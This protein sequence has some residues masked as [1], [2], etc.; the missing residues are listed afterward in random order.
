MNLVGHLGLLAN[1]LLPIDAGT[2]RSK[3]LALSLSGL[4]PLLLKTVRVCWSWRQWAGVV[5]GWST[6]SST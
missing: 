1:W 3:L 4:V 2:T 6:V 5:G